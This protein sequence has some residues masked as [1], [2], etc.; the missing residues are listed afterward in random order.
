MKDS[1]ASKSRQVQPT[2]RQLMLWY[3][4]HPSIRRMA[5]LARKC[6][7]PQT[8]GKV[9]RIARMRIGALATKSQL[10]TAEECGTVHSL[11][12]A[13]DVLIKTDRLS[14]RPLQPDDLDDAVCLIPPSRVTALD[15]SR[16]RLEIQMLLEIGRSEASLVLRTTDSDRIVGMFTITRFEIDGRTEFEIGYRVHFSEER[17]GFATEA[18]RA[19]VQHLLGEC[20]LNRVIALIESSNIASIRVAE[21]VGMRYEKDWQLGSTPVGVYVLSH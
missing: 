19:I 17:R 21:K 7:A 5:A 11:N 9:A 15:L 8:F 20:G 16:E 6:L 13:P 14:I 4:R 10:Q 2:T 1:V 3:L 18:A 12:I